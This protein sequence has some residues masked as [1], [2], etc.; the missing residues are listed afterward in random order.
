HL[1]A[2]LPN[3]TFSA[4]AHYHHLTDDIIVGGKMRY[5]NG[6]IRVPEGPGLGVRL[7]HDKVRQY[8]ELYRELGG[9]AYDRDP[10]RRDWYALVPNEQ[11]ADPADTRVPPLT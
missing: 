3:L 9:Y 5:E 8:A 2:V 1:G 10:G 6:R 11:W 7:D 4:D